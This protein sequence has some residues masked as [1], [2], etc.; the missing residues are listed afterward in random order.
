MK[1]ISRLSELKTLF[2]KHGVS[3]IYIKHLAPHQDNDKNQIM[4][5]SELT[6][7]PFPMV[8]ESRG[9]SK[10]VA[11]K[12]SKK[13]ESILQA[14]LDFAWMDQNADLHEAPDA[15]II[16]YQQY[17]EIRFSGFLNKCT[18]RPDALRK[19]RIYH[20]RFQS[21]AGILQCRRTGL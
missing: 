14:K 16:H 6:N 1:G 2:G 3:R 15:K 9:R 7:L 18:C 19:R 12:Y 5:G 8:I 20:Q 13:G 17:P 11:K 10:S 4:L 21:P